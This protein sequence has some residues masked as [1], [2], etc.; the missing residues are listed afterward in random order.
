MRLIPGTM[1]YAGGDPCKEERKLLLGAA[2]GKRGIALALV[3][4]A[5]QFEIFK[6][7]LDLSFIWESVRDYLARYNDLPKQRMLA[8]NLI[9]TRGLDW[10]NEFSEN[11]LRLL[12]SELYDIAADPPPDKQ[13][14]DILQNFRNE[15]ISAE[16]PEK[17]RRLTDPTEIAACLSQA[18]RN[19]LTDPLGKPSILNPFSDLESS[20]QFA[21]KIPFGLPWLDKLMGGGM[22]VG[23]TFGLVIPS[24][25]GKTTLS[26]MIADQGI[27]GGYKVAKLSFEQGLDGDMTLRPAVLASGSVRSV[28]LRYADDLRAH[29]ANP[30]LPRPELASYLDPVH[31]DRFQ[32]MRPLWERGFRFID[33]SDPDKSILGV[34]A[35]LE[36]TIAELMATGFKPDIIILDWWGRLVDIIIRSLGIT[37]DTQI[38]KRITREGLANLK[39][40]A[41]KYGFRAIVMHQMGGASAAVSPKGKSSTHGAQGDKDF[42][43]M[44][45]YCYS[46]TNKDSDQNIMIHAD[47]SRGAA[48]DKVLLN[49]RGEECLLVPVAPDEGGAVVGAKATYAPKKTHTWGM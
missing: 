10:Q 28:W 25:C 34:G 35:L 36:N 46:S 40:L 26:Y 21:A 37:A 41:G 43:N 45:D 4:L 6:P 44:F 22:G 9:E 47:K 18:S 31:L 27:Q 20:V 32:K 42:N 16:T 33:C 39:F 24:G 30:H 7:S 49:I 11:D 3:E 2:L 5:D 1:M 12:L 48:S 14:S 17:L 13:V 38:S 19:L 8:V 15:F 23:E 29:R